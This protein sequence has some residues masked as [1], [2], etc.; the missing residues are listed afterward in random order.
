[1]EALLASTARCSKSD[2]DPQNPRGTFRLTAPRAS[3]KAERRSSGGAAGAPRLAVPVVPA[4]RA[5]LPVAAG[6]HAH[7]RRLSE[8]KTRSFQTPTQQLVFPQGN[9]RRPGSP[10]LGRSA[11]GRP[12]RRPPPA[13]RPR[14]GAAPRLPERPPRGRDVPGGSRRSPA[15]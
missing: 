7:T 6:Q 1:M 9:K 4:G 12:A 15:R 2:S 5:W 11:R 8:F 3:L 14:P 13:A 10:C